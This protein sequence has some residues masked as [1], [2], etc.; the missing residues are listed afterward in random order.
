MSSLQEAAPGGAE[1]SSVE[2]FLN[3]S[4][5]VRAHEYLC[6]SIHVYIQFIHGLKQPC[7]C[8]SAS[9]RTRMLSNIKSVT[10]V[11]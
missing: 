2:A 7:V 9:S 1:K 11:L 3:L 10:A 4:V 6:V 5:H 8:R